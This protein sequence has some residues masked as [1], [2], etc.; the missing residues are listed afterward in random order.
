MCL[1]SAP[2]PPPPPPPPPPLP[3]PAKRT[4]PEVKAAKVSAR[5]T[6]ALAQGRSGTLLGGQLTSQ[7][8]NQP[9]KTLLGA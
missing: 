9:R 3:E 8:E 5:K 4:D 6:A 2:S 1:A 7:P